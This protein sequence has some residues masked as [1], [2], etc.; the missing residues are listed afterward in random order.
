[1]IPPV[2]YR[3]PVP[4]DSN[5]HRNLK[6][7]ELPDYS[8]A[9]TMHMAYVSVAELP[10]AALDFVVVFVDAA[11]APPGGKS[12]VL[13]VVLLG[14]QL[15]ENLYVKDGQWTSRYA[16]AFFRRHP[17]ANGPRNGP[18]DRPVV[19][20]DTA[21]PRLSETAGRALFSDDGKPSEDL[22]GWMGFVDMFDRELQQS[23]EFCALLHKHD[24]LKPS[25]AQMTLPGGEEMVL[26]GFFVFDPDKF[27]ALPAQTRLELI[28]NGALGV[29]HA[30][31]TSLGNL[32]YLAERKARRAGKSDATGPV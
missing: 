13:P 10:V 12:P 19:L 11:P 2:L 28:D 32:R 15:E 8:G 6:L 3:Q 24:L 29:L 14:A 26:N 30:H 4:L 23:A 25:S 1:M 9:S 21:S 27:R 20:I 7:A 17:F 22:V 18:A 31:Q 16:P 5:L